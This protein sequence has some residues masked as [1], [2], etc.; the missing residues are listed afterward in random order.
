LLV[1]CSGSDGAAGPAG[2]NGS[3]GATGPAGATGAAGAAGAAGEAGAP[4]PAGDAGATG[5]IGPDQ[6]PAAVY[7]LSNDASSNE[8]V[9]YARASDGNLT[10]SGSYATGGQGLGA[11]LG[12]QGGL[13]FQPSTG[14]FF[15]VNAGDNSISMLSLNE[16]GS[17]TML[18]HVPSGGSVPDTITVSGDTVYVANEGVAGM[19]SA[20]ISG[21]KVTGATLA[22]IASS[23]QALSAANPIPVDISFTPD[24]TLL[25][26]TEKATNM[27][28]TFSVTAGVAGTAKVQASVG[29]TPFGFAFDAAGHLIV[30]EAV[31]GTAFLSS[32]TS[33]SVAADG[34]LTPITSSLATGQSSA[35]WL[36]VA[37][38]WSYVANTGSADLTALG[39][40]ATGAVSLLTATGDSA[41][42][43]HGSIDVAATPDNGFLYSLSATDHTITI[44]NI[45]ADGTLVAQPAL[46]GVPLHAAG[47][48]AR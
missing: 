43:G 26:V 39:V 24:G 10:L 44:L 40:S 6:P 8:V 29:E 12:S 36:T 23:T 14:L 47:L 9:V 3:A 35:C 11:G 1:A 17:L 19:S 32:V 34:T 45:Q 21:F 18:S 13:V 38:N 25:V 7:T 5:P 4:G 27:I 28:D 31:G 16:D 22:P 33:Y 30:S 42:S 15:A 37:A 41:P 46:A 48:V 20:N 2:A